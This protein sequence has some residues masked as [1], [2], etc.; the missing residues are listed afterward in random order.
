MALKEARTIPKR[1]M[2]IQTITE[3]CAICLADDTVFAGYTYDFLYHHF[4][5]GV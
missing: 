3:Q 4:M 1:L 2:P 5:Q